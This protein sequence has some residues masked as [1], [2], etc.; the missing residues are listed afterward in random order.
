M[1]AA[2]PI[3]GLPDKTDAEHGAEQNNGGIIGAETCCKDSEYGKC[4]EKEKKN[5]AEQPFFVVMHL[6]KSSCVRSS[7]NPFVRY[8]T[9]TV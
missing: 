3:L 5:A 6:K 7:G 1:C 9:Y 2:L 4:R 8:P